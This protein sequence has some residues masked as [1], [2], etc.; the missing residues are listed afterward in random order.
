[1]KRLVAVWILACVLAAAPV[2][3]QPTPAPEPVLRVKL[4]PQRVVVGQPVTLRIELLVPNYMTTPPEFPDLQLRN[5]VSRPLGHMNISEEQQGITYAGVVREIAIHPQEPGSYAISGQSVRFAYAAEPPAIRQATLDLPS[6][7]FEAF[8]PEAAQSLQPFIAASRLVLR[9]TIDPK[10][11][12]LKVGDAVVRTVTIEAQ[13]LPAMLLPATSFTAADG[14]AVYPDQPALEDKADQRTDELAGT[15]TDRATYMLQK[16]GDYVLPGIDVQRWNIEAQKIE[17]A[18]IEPVSLKVAPN[19]ALPQGGGQSAAGGGSGWRAWLEIVATH[20]PWVAAALSVLAGL[21]FL[22]PRALA[23]LRAWHARRRAV[24]LQSEAC[25]FDRLRQAARHGDAGRAYFA[26]LEWL[27]RFDP[28]APAHTVES[29]RNAARD[30]S[31]DEQL[32]VI[33]SRLF[34]AQARGAVPDDA[35]RRLLRRLTIV[36]RRL[37]RDAAGRR[38][39]RPLAAT[40]NPRGRHAM[41][42]GR[43]RP[44]AR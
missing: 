24:W 42:S 20:W 10:P 25:A 44:V 27:A 43:Y 18:H 30:Q 29:L 41:A 14:L 21:A 5:A 33:E 8:I 39:T 32:T 9:Q 35:P 3:A 11:E 12:G 17:R 37:A 13:G 16:P 6:L 26:L 22:A 23:S 31:L 15:R 38:G 19:P 36:R 2:L 34:A 4:E 7:S 40:L 28:V 1:M